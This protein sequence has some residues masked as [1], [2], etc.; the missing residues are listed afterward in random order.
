MRHVPL[1][2]RILILALVVASFAAQAK[3]LQPLGFS[4]GL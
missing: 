4:R 1:L 2:A 3:G